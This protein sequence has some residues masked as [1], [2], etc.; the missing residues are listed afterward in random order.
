MAAPISGYEV[1]T[2]HNKFP[3]FGITYD[4]ALVPFRHDIFPT[5]SSFNVVTKFFELVLKDFDSPSLPA[6]P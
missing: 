4:D 6:Y 3:Y 2:L 1:P 5:S